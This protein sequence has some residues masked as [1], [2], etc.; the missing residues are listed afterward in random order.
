MVRE[1]AAT[2]RSRPACSSASRRS[3]RP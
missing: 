3:R 2:G 1:G